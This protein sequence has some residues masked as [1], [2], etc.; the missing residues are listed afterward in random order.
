[1]EFPWVL[2]KSLRSWFVTLEFPPTNKDRV[3]TGSGNSG[4]VRKFVR[5]QE[6]CQGRNVLSMQIFNFNKKVMCTQECLQLNC[7]WQSVVYMILLFASSIKIIIVQTPA[8]PPP[9]LFKVG[10]V[11]LITSIGEVEE[12]DK[13]KKEVESMQVFLKRVRGGGGVSWH[14]YYL[15]FSRFIIFLFRN[16]F[17]LCKILLCIWRKI[18]FFCH[19]NFMNKGDSKLPKKE[20]KIIP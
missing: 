1:M 10:G 14:F 20:P 13:L 19:H 15:F 5:G 18:M 3:S 2:I 11:I 9:A 7:I 16:Y 4:K 8:P 12:S 6:K 17:T